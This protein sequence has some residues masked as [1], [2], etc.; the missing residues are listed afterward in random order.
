MNLHSDQCLNTRFI[1]L[2]L[3]AS[4]IVP[5]LV[6]YSPFILTMVYAYIMNAPV[7]TE[8]FYFKENNL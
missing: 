1:L 8:I 5:K 6:G 3:L 7:N 4:Y 2:P